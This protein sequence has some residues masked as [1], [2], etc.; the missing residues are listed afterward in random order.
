M[1]FHRELQAGKVSLAHIVDPPILRTLVIAT[2]VARPL[3]PATQYVMD[4]TIDLLKAFID[5]ESAKP[6]RRPR[7]RKPARRV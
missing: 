4:S 3:S 6:V 7:G 2:P 1:G 5:A